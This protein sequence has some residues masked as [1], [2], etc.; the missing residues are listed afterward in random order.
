METEDAVR[1][2]LLED[3]A[4]F[5]KVLNLIPTNFYFSEDVR[6]KMKA[7]TDKT[8]TTKKAKKRHLGDTTIKSHQ[9]KNK[10]DPT[11][12]KNVTELQEYLI[13]V[14]QADKYLYLLIYH[15]YSGIR[16]TFYIPKSTPKSSVSYMR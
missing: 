8:D 5:K 12:I 3:N 15:I 2:Q 10:Y 13:E 4:Y 16:R 6:Q 11:Q 1:K 9:K 7:H 14:E